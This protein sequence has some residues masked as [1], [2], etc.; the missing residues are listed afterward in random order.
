MTRLVDLLES[1]PA[2]REDDMCPVCEDKLA[3]VELHLD[4]AATT[5]Q[6]SHHL[7][8]RVCHGC[9]STLFV[10]LSKVLGVSDA[11]AD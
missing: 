9:A 2:P 5:A 11:E 3:T 6:S 4:L 7:H 10:S 1:V 8:T